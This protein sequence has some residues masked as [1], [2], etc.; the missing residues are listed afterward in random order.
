MVILFVVDLAIMQKFEYR[1]PRFPVDFP[2]QFT[3]GNLTATGRCREISRAGMILELEQPHPVNTR[4]TVIVSHQ[5]R[6]IE[7]Q[8]RVAHTGP[9]HDGLEFLYGSDTERA[10]MA[11]MV[12]S[13]AAWPN[14]PGPILLS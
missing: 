6:T 1:T 4:G 9:T 8:V 13:L 7:L 3:V 14:R 2:V 11:Q 12:A 10:E 5:D